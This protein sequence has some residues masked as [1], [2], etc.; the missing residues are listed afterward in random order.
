VMIISRAT[1]KHR[2]LALDSGVDIFLT[3]P[4][5]DTE[6]LQHVRTLAGSASA[7]VLMQL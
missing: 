5:T 2:Q 6:L 4:Y 7:S 3:K 1:D